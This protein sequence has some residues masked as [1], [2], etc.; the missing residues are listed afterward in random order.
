METIKSKVKKLID[1]SF[2]KEEQAS[3]WV[4]NIVFVP[5]KNEKIRIC[6]NFCELNVACPKDKFPLPI[7]KLD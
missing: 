1:S 2:I 3:D 7:T 6:N 5:K 4:A